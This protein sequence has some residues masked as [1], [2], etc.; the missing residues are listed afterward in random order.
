[1][2]PVYEVEVR[3]RSLGDLAR[4][5]TAEQADRMRAVA[6]RSA[7]TLSGRTVWNVNST[8]SPTMST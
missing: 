4:V 2:S 8:A 1:M 5:L 3:R 7:T 6:A